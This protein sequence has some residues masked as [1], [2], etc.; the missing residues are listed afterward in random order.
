MSKGFRCQLKAATSKKDEAELLI[1]DEIGKSFWGEGVEAK[2]VIK[3]LATVTA[4]KI[5]VRIN[6]IG[7]DVFDALAI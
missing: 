3:D 1:Y 5:R 7:G 6:S 2:Q 4:K